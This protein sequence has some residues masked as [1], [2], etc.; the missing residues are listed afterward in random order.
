MDV[1]VVL[2]LVW[3]HF[4][5]DFIIQSDRMARDK[6]NSNKW[7]GIHCLAYSIPFIII[8]PLYALIN[9]LLHFM[10]D[11]VTSRQTIKLWRKK[12]AHWFFVGIGLDQA[13]HITALVLTYNYMFT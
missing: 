8:S 2:T 3:L 10:T 7:L 5:A 9:G 1:M 13:L 12:Q 4:F 6:S 11:Y